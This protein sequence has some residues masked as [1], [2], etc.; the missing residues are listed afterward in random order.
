M[1]CCYLSAV[2]TSRA[3]V[4]TRSSLDTVG[5]EYQSRAA[6]AHIVTDDLGR[7]YI[8][9]HGRIHCEILWAE[10][11]AV[12]RLRRRLS[13]DGGDASHNRNRWFVRG[14][15]HHRIG[16]R[17]FDDTCTALYPGEWDLLYES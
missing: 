13:V 1:C 10:D 2:L 3:G 16:E 17:T 14:K 11:V 15:T 5:L 6:A 8:I 7:I 12:D 9:V 4:W